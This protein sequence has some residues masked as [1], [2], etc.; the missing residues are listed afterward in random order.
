MSDTS[1]LHLVPL[2]PSKMAMADIKFGRVATKI[3]T[4]SNIPALKSSVQRHHIPPHL[5]QQK[6][7]L[8]MGIAY[9]KPLPNG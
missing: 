3:R 9:E 4:S 8:E 7:R 6:I 2:F 5:Q 1:I